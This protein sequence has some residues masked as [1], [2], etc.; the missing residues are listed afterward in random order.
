M[1]QEIKT[2]HFSHDDFKHFTQRLEAETQLLGQWFAD[3]QLS[4]HNL[5]GGYELEAWL[6]DNQGQPSPSNQQFLERANSPL[7]TP[8]LAQF[9]VELNSFCN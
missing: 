6:I 1:G 8:E 7:L 9:N 3:N 4:S 2:R 5:V